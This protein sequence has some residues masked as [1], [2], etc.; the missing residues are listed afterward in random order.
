MWRFP[1][2]PSHPTYLFELFHVMMIQNNTIFYYY[3]STKLQTPEYFPVLWAGS[4]VMS[5]NHLISGLRTLLSK[6][7]EFTKNPGRYTPYNSRNFMVYADGTD[8]VPGV[9]KVSGLR[10][11]TEPICDHD[12]SKSGGP[13]FSPG[14]TSYEPIRLERGR[15]HDKTFEQWA[16]KVY[17]IS[18]EEGKKTSLKDYKKDIR[19]VLRNEAGQPVIA[20]NVFNCWPIEYVAV[21]EFDA[22]CSNTATESLTLQHE[23]WERDY[24][25]KEPDQPSFR[26]PS[27]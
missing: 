17:D 13:V 16:N 12:G 22:S 2:T 27:E 25:V 14:E 11:C 15:T 18:G 26:K 19:I 23:G 20:F 24:D 1:A 8:P 10:R 6:M 5:I 7:A 21:D 9:S 3:I 4:T